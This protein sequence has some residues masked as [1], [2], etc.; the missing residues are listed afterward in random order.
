MNMRNRMA[1]FASRASSD[2]H[3]YLFFKGKSLIEDAM[4][5]NIISN[6]FFVILP[7]YGLEGFIEFLK[8]DQEWNEG[9]GKEEIRTRFRIKGRECRIFDHVKVRIEVEL[10][11]FHKQINLEY[12]G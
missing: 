4:I 6:G 7:R 3:T 2:Y 5:T 10:K 8:E 9:S 12:V 1:R 11:S